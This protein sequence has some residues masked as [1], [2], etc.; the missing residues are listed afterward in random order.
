M[1]STVDRLLQKYEWILWFG[2][3]FDLS[4]RLKLRKIRRYLARIRAEA[5]RWR[6]KAWPNQIWPSEK[7]PEF[8]DTA[9]VIIT[10]PNPVTFGSDNPRV[11]SYA[12]LYIATKGFCK[13]ELLGSGG[14][15]RVYKAVLPSDGSIVAVKCLSENG[16]RSSLEK[17]F[18]A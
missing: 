5:S 18:E 7:G 1:D 6:W 8:H 2:G 16:E 4:P 12:E 9:G 17:T 14:F 3:D 15:G 10:M 13:E 11:F